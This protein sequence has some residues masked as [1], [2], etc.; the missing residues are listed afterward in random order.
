VN[1]KIAEKIT[2]LK[3]YAQERNIEIQ[4]FQNENTGNHAIIE[5]FETFGSGVKSARMWSLIQ[6]T[7]TG[8]A[9]IKTTW[10]QGRKSERVSGKDLLDSLDYLATL[11]KRHAEK[12][13]R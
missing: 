10:R 12:A 6:L 8:R 11:N 2:E 7:T 9:S 3:N 13:A 1:I 4:L 5:F